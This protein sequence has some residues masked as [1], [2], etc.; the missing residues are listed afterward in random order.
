MLKKGGDPRGMVAHRGG[1][2]DAPGILLTRIH[3]VAAKLS[4]E[5]RS[6]RVAAA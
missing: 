2:H 4:Y 5:P 1:A 3:K 6:H